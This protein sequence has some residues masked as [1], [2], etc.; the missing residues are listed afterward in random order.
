MNVDIQTGGCRR[1]SARII[2]NI[3]VGPSP[4]WVVKHLESIGERSINNIVDAT[5]LVM[6][7]CGQPTHAYDLNKVASSKEQLV[8]IK[9]QNAKEGEELALVGR[10]GIVAKLKESDVVICDTK[11]NNL[12]LAGVKGGTESGI[13][14]GT[15]D[16]VLEV[17]NFDPI[18][19]RKTARRIGVLS[20]AAKRFENDLTPELC[21]FAMLE[22]SALLMETCPDAVLEEVVD[23]YP[24]K[25]NWAQDHKITFTT[26]MIAYKLGLDISELDIEKILNNY[27]YQYSLANSVFEIVVPK[28]RL[29]LKIPVD[30]VEEIGRVYGY[31]KIV[32]TLPQ[33]NN[34]FNTKDNSIYTQISN[35]RNDLM[36]NGYREV[37]T[38][39]FRKKGDVQVARGTKGK[40]FLRT[41]LSDGLKESYELNRLNAPLI[42]VD[43]VK[44]FEIGTVF[45]N[46][47]EE[48]HVAYADKK[49]ITEVNISE[50]ICDQ[51]I[52]N[53]DNL[54]PVD[55]LKFEM[56]SPYPFI[57]RDISVW[58]PEETN[59][60]ELENICKKCGGELLMH[61]PRLVD[62]F[63]KDGK[64]SYAYR[65]VFQAKDRT[66]KDEEVSVIMDLINTEISKNS[67]WIIR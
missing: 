65:L 9:I 54:L 27:G 14:D 62:K 7:N 60:N 55:N 45:T 50:Y 53:K 26:D 58:V 22:L 6:Y 19:V 63:E 11:G 5:N 21:E 66:L 18:C 3:K 47:N 32:P 36:S 12:A 37:M 29:D 39:T 4:E 43:D 52:Q 42:N 38:Y 10:S 25:E 41:N 61:N 40:D 51:N 31:D 15:V 20:D 13:N 24:N 28:M 35:T 46:S 1:Y 67:S 57:T 34:V 17:A 49:G 64:V 16:I 30:M 56:W 2:R 59:A 48:I 8:S 44:V 33:I 23:I